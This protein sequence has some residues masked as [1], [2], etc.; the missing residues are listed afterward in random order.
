MD[1]WHLPMTILPGIG[2]LILSTSNLMITLSNEIASLMKEQS[3]EE[4]IIS[5][6]LIQ[7]K[8][9]NRAMVFFYVAVAFLAITGVLGGLQITSI[10]N[11]LVYL[12]VIGIVIMLSGIFSLIKYSYKA[13]SIRQDQFT[14]KFSEK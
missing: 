12:A 2:L 14:T 6:K 5:R 3:K 7:L 4:S 8:T 11:S 13:V 9:L 1:N 10:K